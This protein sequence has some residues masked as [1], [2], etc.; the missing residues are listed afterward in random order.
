MTH[1]P[2]EP[3]SDITCEQVAAWASAYLEHQLPDEENVRIVLHLAACAGCDAYVKQIASIRRVLAQL[4][5]TAPDPRRR[6][7]LRHAFSSRRQ[8]RL[9]P[10]A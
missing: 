3:M 1:Q 6:H 8:R 7:R 9:P 4:P 10:S 2:S 5:K